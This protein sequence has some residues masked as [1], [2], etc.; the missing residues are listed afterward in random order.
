MDEAIE[1]TDADLLHR[2]VSGDERAFR[3]LFR[4]HERACY[5][6]ALSM[7]GTSWDAEEVVGA[8][9]AALWRKRTSVRVV[10]NSVLPW[11]VAAVSYASKNQLRGMRRYR[12]LVAH[13]PHGLDHPDHADE[14]ARVVDSIRIASDVQQV[15]AQLN[16]RDAAVVMLCLV[17]ELPV[18]DVAVVLG[19]PEGTVKSRLSRAKAKLRRGLARYSHVESEPT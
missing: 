3:A 5:R 2:I 9:F 14:V 17:Q 10:D 12:R 15:L 18:Y 13:I 7:V 1:P 19:V 8:A 11:L 4:R 6:V 16:A